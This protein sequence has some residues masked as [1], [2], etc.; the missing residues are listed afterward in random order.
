[1]LNSYK[2]SCGIAVDGTSLVTIQLIQSKRFQRLYNA[3][4]YNKFIKIEQHHFRLGLYE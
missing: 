1:M 2:I 4:D 3:Y